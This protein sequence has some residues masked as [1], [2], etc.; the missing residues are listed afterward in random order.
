MSKIVALA[1]GSMAVVGAVITSGHGV[2]HRAVPAASDALT[3]ATTNVG[4]SLSSA[5]QAPK[6]AQAPAAPSTTPSP[7]SDQARTAPSTIHAPNDPSE[8]SAA[9]VSSV[10]VASGSAT[11]ESRDETNGQPRADQNTQSVTK[12]TGAASREGLPDMA[13]KAANGQE[14]AQR[15]PLVDADQPASEARPPQRITGRIVHAPS[16]KPGVPDEVMVL[17]KQ[18]KMLKT[19]ETSE[20]GP[21]LANGA[22]VTA[23]M[24]GGQVHISG[25]DQITYKTAFRGGNP[26]YQGDRTLHVVQVIPAAQQ[27]T[28]KSGGELTRL[29]RAVH[30]YYARESNGQTTFTKTIIHPALIRSTNTCEQ[31]AALHDEVLNAIGVS[32]TWQDLN[33]EDRTHVLAVMPSYGSCPGGRAYVGYGFGYVTNGLTKTMIHEVGHQLGLRHAAAA[34]CNDGRTDVDLATVHRSPH[35]QYYNYGDR[36]DVMGAVANLQNPGAMTAAH[37]A[38]LGYLNTRIRPIS[39]GTEILAPFADRTAFTRAVSYRDEKSRSTYH[40]F[41][42]SKSVGQD[43]AFFAG[44]PTI[45]RGP[46]PGVV[47][48]KTEWSNPWG[49]PV[50]ILRQPASRSWD[51]TLPLGQKLDF[52]DGALSVT[53]V[54]LDDRGAQLDVTIKGISHHAATKTANRRPAGSQHKTQSA[55]TAST[56]SPPVHKDAVRQTAVQK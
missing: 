9:S 24:S 37:G 30:E 20:K 46:I 15:W 36:Y 35:C 2:A 53:V 29:G 3:Q 40:F 10:S 51:Q 23:T 49:Q 43:R 22:T 32:S 50:L 21:R 11:G 26:L 54:S 45:Q 47:V 56:Q 18:G 33:I 28:P 52:A 25:A 19:T 4:T 44:L 7:K 39:P 38:K 8:P 17:T 14:S 41:Y 13:P 1:I 27:S 16:E 31:L 12:V 34:R 6:P 5:P 42:R 55:Q 48:T